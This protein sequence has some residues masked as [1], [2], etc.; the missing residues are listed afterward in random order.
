[1]LGFFLTGA[2]SELTIGEFPRLLRRMKEF[3]NEI[4]TLP[5]LPNNR[6]Q[7]IS[8]HANLNKELL[9]IIHSKSERLG[10]F[11]LLGASAMNYVLQESVNLDLARQLRKQ[12]VQYLADIQISEDVLDTFL[13]NS[14]TKGKEIDLNNLHSASLEFARE[15]IK[16]T[17]EDQKVAFVSMP[18]ILEDRYFDFYLPLLKKLGYIGFRAWGG[19]ANEYYQ[20]LMI[21]LIR[22]SGTVLVDL[23][24]LNVNVIYEMGLAHGMKKSVFPIVD[25]T[26]TQ[27]PANFGDLSI[28]QYNS[29][30][31]ES[32]I[33]SCVS[34]ISLM[35]FGE[36][37]VQEE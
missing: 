11:A 4:D 26:Q 3:L 6:D 27:V 22:K 35:Q 37:L 29:N 13:I 17:S 32:S 25:E 21:E 7:F 18:F 36:K 24:G 15:I 23:T 12:A 14:N 34:L 28:A 2:Y 16:P 20:E 19:L 8:G 5:I 33:H 31:I 30:D 1:M 10:K 9:F